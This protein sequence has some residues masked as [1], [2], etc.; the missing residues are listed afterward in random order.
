MVARG[1]LGGYVSD[2]LHR[3]GACCVQPPVHVHA[4][5][6]CG[7]SGLRRLQALGMGPRRAV[8]GTSP[9][10]REARL[11]TASVLVR[12]CALMLL[13]STR[14]RRTRLRT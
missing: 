7:H 4:V 12:G 10:H 14:G 2:A 3:P 6:L 1:G 5:C 11:T 13:A 9:M 8:R